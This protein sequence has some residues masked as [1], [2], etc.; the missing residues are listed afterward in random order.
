MSIFCPWH[1][2]EGGRAS[3]RVDLVHFLCRIGRLDPPD[4]AA[5]QLN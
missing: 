5:E 1:N 4:A 3:P 2:T